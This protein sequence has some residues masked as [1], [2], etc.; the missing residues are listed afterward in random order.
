M[1]CLVSKVRTAGPRV[2]VEAIV[3]C[4]RPSSGTFWGLE[5]HLSAWYSKLDPE[6]GSVFD[7]RTK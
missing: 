3:V 4:F 5:V 2:V 1:A 7:F 6:P